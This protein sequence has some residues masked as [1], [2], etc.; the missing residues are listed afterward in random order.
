MKKVYL[1]MSADLI[2]PGHINIIK[3]AASYGKVTV[4]LLT[5]QAISTY[6]RV[7][8]M[9]YDQRK[10]V[11]ENIKHVDS[12]VEQKTLS[13]VENI[14]NL[15]PDYV[16]H[17][18]DWKSG[19]QKKTRDEAII[20]L[21]KIGG[22]LIEVEYT[23][24]ISSSKIKNAINEVGVT[25]DQ[26]LSSLRRLLRAKP[27]ITLNEVHNGLSGIITNNISV[28]LENKTIEFDG[29]WASSLTD[30]TAKGMPDIEAVDVTSRL[31]SVNSILGVTN[32]LMIFDADTGGIRE[33]FN[34]TVK[35]LERLGVSAAVIEDK[36]GLKKN[37]L[38]GTDVEQFQDKIENFQEKIQSGKSAQISNDFMIIARI[39]SLILNKGMDDALLRARSYIDAGADAIM[40]HSRVKS[41]DEIFEFCKQFREF[42]SD[43]PLMVVPSSFNIVKIEEWEKR[44]V[45]I[46]CYANHMI[47]SA[48][49]AMQK[50]AKSILLNGRS[51]E[52][53]E[54]EDCMPIKDILNLISV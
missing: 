40:I 5:D 35:A 38:F 10:Q 16:I 15:K 21:N 14:R 39:E 47:R 13:Y 46:V 32:K 51:F 22:K 26:R 48:Y 29:M 12:V 53:D 43:L 36:V 7:P 8:Y 41:P 42:N 49:P 20:A 2:H 4:G 6:K 3:K 52:V 19:I 54:N 33:H 30:S 31:Q 1:G 9:T 28:E 50:V 37:S 24:G 11:I 27:I 34:F 17:G 23:K 18:D 45:N 44:G 25:P